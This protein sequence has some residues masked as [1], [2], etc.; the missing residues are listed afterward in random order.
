[1]NNLAVLYQDQRRYDEARQL[2]ERAIAITEKAR[3]TKDAR[4]PVYIHTLGEL[5]QA[6]GNLAEAERQLRR[7]VEIYE[8]R[9]GHRLLGL[10]L[11]QLAGLSALQRR[12]EQ[13]L[14]FLHQALKKGWADESIV[15]DDNLDSLR[16][17]ADFEVIVSEVKSRIANTKK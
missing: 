2:L 13:A 7:A 14:D 17:R 11:Y 1:M 15:E 8:S 10:G 6:T 12:P 4:Y 16:G 3:G 5:S 9:G